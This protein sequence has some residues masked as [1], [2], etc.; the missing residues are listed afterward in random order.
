MLRKVGGRRVGPVRRRR[1]VVRPKRMLRKGPVGKRWIGK[2]QNYASLKENY[3]F[4]FVAGNTTFFRSTQ[5]ADL[6]FDR[7]QAVAQAYQQ[8]RIKYIKMTFKPNNDTYPAG[9]AANLPQLYFMVDKTNAIPTNAD[10]NTFYSIG[11]RPIRVD[12]KNIV[13][14]FKPCA[15]VAND[16]N[17]GVTTA[18]MLKV[19]PWLSTNANAGN[20]GAVWAPS[21]V[22]HIG[23]VFYITKTNPADAQ[24]Y[25]VDVEIMFEFRRPSWVKG[26]S[27][28]Y[29]KIVNGQTITVTNDLSGNQL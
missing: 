23:A 15:L 6:I 28:S 26:S 24:Q 25:G 10:A 5:L 1:R 13:K 11:T 7:A 9:G 14:A 12:D 27:P 19:S 8:Y 21:S 4:D 29:D 18:N 22:D 16:V 17:P 3:Q 20:P 2:N